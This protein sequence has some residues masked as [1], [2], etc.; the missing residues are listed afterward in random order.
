MAD[1]L[2][3]PFCPYQAYPIVTTEMYKEVGLQAYLC[4]SKHLSYVEKEKVE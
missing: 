1:S 2:N 4:A 3:C